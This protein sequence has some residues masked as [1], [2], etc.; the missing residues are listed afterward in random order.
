M[1]KQ[2][3][4]LPIS[5]VLSCLILGGFFCFVRLN[6][7]KPVEYRQSKKI[8]VSNSSLPKKIGECS[9]TKVLKVGQRLKDGITGQD[10]ANSGSE[11]E[12]A[13]GIYQVSYDNIAGIDNSIIGDGVNLCL[14]SVPD[15]CPIGDSRGKVYEATNLRTSETWTAGDSQHGCGGA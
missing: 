6:K 4:I 15:N 14:V 12:Y 13:N 9:K 5:I 3:L 7:Q 10:I 1:N 8:P 11:I 2:K